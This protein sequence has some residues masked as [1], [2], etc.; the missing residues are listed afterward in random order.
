MKDYS[1]S[2]AFGNN[3]RIAAENI[4][5]PGP[6][7]K[8]GY[9]SLGYSKMENWYS[10]STS[11]YAEAVNNTS[12]TPTAYTDR[13]AYFYEGTRSGSYY[14]T[15]NFLWFDTGSILTQYGITSSDIISVGLRLEYIISVYYM[16][17][18]ATV[19]FKA[20][21]DSSSRA[22]TE[23]VLSS[24]NYADQSKQAI[25]SYQRQSG[26][27]SSLYTIAY[28]P[29]LGFKDTFNWTGTTILA[30]WATLSNPNNGYINGNI[31]EG[32]LDI[33]FKY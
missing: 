3:N 6:Q 31:Y 19:T 22:L 25:F 33:Y 27:S 4:Q 26:D 9:V 23:T 2:R 30:L 21:V 18:G 20:C 17:T 5:D 29:E 11:S 8:V 32:S 1:L 24:G 14:H 10:S 12:I 28:K 7:K 13:W 15:Y 16:P